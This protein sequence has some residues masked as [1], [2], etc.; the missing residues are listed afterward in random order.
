MS[1]DD[2]LFDFDEE[3]GEKVDTAEITADTRAEIAQKTAAK[4]KSGKT[5]GKT[6]GRNFR[7]KR[8]PMHQRQPLSIQ[9]R[10]PN[11]KY[12]VV[13]D[14]PGRVERFKL[15]GWVVDE[16]GTVG[17]TIAGRATSVD[18]VTSAPVGQGITGIVM[19]IPNELY[20]EDQETKQAKVDELEKSML[21]QAKD[22]INTAGGV[23][24]DAVRGG[25]Q[26]NR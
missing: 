25:V 3:N 21:E 20:E 16:G 15:A 17:D 19:K 23:T 26:I 9:N 4:P 10:D 5:T 12:R 14:K 8:V 24:E 6:T 11:F 7:Q 13:N 2:D 18:S 22:E 1:N